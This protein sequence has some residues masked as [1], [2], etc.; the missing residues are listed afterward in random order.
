M[1]NIDPEK[2]KEWKIKRHKLQNVGKTIIGQTKPYVHAG[3]ANDN[4]KAIGELCVPL[5]TRQQ[6]R[7]K[8]L[9]YLHNMPAVLKL[10]DRDRAVTG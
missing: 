5:E 1:L 7:K 9:A 3:P 2:Q 8:T 6:R 10:R 4:D